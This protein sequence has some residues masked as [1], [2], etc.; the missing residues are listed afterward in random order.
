MTATFQGKQR[1]GRAI[2]PCP[3]T[4]VRRACQ[5][6][7][8]G[9]FSHSD[10]L[11]ARSGIWRSQSPFQT[12]DS[13]LLRD[14]TART[15]QFSPGIPA[16]LSMRACSRSRRTSRISNST[17]KLSCQLYR[18]L[19]MIFILSLPGARSGPD[20]SV[21]NVWPHCGTRLS[22]LHLCWMRKP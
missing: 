5:P 2:A 13:I 7:Q 9:R 22:L 19:F 21:L 20:R 1:I 10:C 11:A 16:S 15:A 4:R 17:I 14:F 8:Q 6:A 3:A 18:L 12:A